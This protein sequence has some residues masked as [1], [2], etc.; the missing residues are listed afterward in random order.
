MV[1]GSRDGST[2]KHANKG[3]DDSSTKVILSSL[4]YLNTEFQGCEG[5]SRDHLCTWII[6]TD[7]RLLLVQP[8]RN[9][10]CNCVV[11]IQ[12]A[13]RCTVLSENE[14]LQQACHA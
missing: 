4:F 2:I 13:V 1:Q 5:K 8:S 14:V 7:V 11:I 3:R 9:N 6:P 12:S 10:Y